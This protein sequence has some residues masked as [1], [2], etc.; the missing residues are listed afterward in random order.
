MQVLPCTREHIPGVVE[1]LTGGGERSG[2]GGQG[3]LCRYLEEVYFDNPW[4][5]PELASLVCEDGSGRIDGFLGVMARPM[6]LND[7]QPIRAATSS[8]FRVRGG[9]QAAPRNPFTAIALLKRFF[10]GPQDLSV[11]NGANRLSKRIWEACGGVAVPLYSLDWFRAIR[12]A[13]A[14]LE[15]AVGQRSRPLPRGVRLLADAVDSAAG[16]W[17]MRASVPDRGGAGYDLH[18][19]DASSVID[20]LAHA[21][22]FDLKPRYD[23]EAF[24]W[25]LEKSRCKAVGGRSRAMARARFLCCERSS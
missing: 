7:R 9:G 18:D 11:A 23:A 12:P 10:E 2:S 25:L 16:N 4:H 14:V 24:A 5:D 13:R 21:R 1:L 6:V 22:G 3:P 15:L 17:L 20:G 8:N 19:L